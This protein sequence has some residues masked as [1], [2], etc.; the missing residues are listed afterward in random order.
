M[1]LK[2]FYQ[3]V[4]AHS[5]TPELPNVKLDLKEPDSYAVKR[6]K[7]IEQLG[8]KWLLHPDNKITKLENVMN[9]LRH[10]KID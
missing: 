9:I 4:S 1:W 6:A 2:Q 10:N 7:A 3:A 5:V 8:T